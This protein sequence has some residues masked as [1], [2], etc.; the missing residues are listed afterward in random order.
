MEYS[1]QYKSK[2]QKQFEERETTQREENFFKN[3]KS[4]DPQKYKRQHCIHKIIIFK[5]NTQRIKQK[6]LEIKDRAAE[7]EKLNRIV[8][9]KKIPQEVE[10]KDGKQMGG[11]QRLI[12]EVQNP[13]SFRKKEQRNEMGQTQ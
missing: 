3:V 10:Q 2:P 6:L 7:I 5:R 8:K 9:G 12:Q 1:N 4:Y 11:G 13:T